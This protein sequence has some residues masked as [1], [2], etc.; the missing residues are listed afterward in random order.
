MFADLSFYETKLK[1]YLHKI[2]GKSYEDQI[3]KVFFFL[4]IQIFLYEWTRYII[5]LEFWWL[6]EV[7]RIL[8][9]LY[10]IFLNANIQLYIRAVL[11]FFLCA[12]DDLIIF[13]IFLL[14]KSRKISSVYLCKLWFKSNPL[15]MHF[16]PTWNIFVYNDF[17]WSIHFI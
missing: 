1:I 3:T 12:A 6:L 13:F 10:R 17:L 9:D 16:S 15:G 5:Y 11:K 2:K 8:Y 14:F 4:N 7:N